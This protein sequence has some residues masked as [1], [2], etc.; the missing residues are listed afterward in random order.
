MRSEPSFNLGMVRRVVPS[1]SAL[2]SS[3]IAIHALTPPRR[4]RITCITKPCG[5]RQCHSYPMAWCWV[6]SLWA[7]PTVMLRLR[8]PS[9]RSSLCSAR[10]RRSLAGRRPCVGPG[11]PDQAGVVGEVALVR[12]MSGHPLGR[13]PAKGTPAFQGNLGVAGVEL[14]RE[15]RALCSFGGD[16]GRAR[17]DEQIED[18]RAGQRAVADGPLH[19][20]D[21]F[22]GR[23]ELAARPTW[24]LPDGVLGPIASEEVLL[25]V[26]PAIQDRRRSQG[27]NASPCRTGEEGS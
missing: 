2:W 11:T 16:Q 13:L 3:L 27:V 26:T 22:G 1:P 6:R 14:H 8:P 25:A 24:D 9:A 10:T 4:C 20:L 23:V 12:A 18:P 5:R 15:T 7:G 21:R 19:E 17:T